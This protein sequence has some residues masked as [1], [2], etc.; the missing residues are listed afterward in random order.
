MN[1]HE[2]LTIGIER[3]WCSN[4]HCD[5]CNGAPLRESEW[6]SA[7]QGEA[8]CCYVVRLLGDYIECSE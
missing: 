3:G 5:T 2:W 1:Q 7:E 4:I 6:E 8:P